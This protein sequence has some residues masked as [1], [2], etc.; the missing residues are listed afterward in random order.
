M[1][2]T[3]IEKIQQKIMKTMGRNFAPKMGHSKKARGK[4]KKR[5]E[6]KGKRKEPQKP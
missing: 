3:N 4:N 6:K 2:I 1:L 5:Y